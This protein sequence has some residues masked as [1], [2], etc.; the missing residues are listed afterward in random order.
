VVV[1]HT[2][3]NTM[4]L[5]LCNVCQY[6]AQ[7]KSIEEA[8]KKACKR[9][10]IYDAYFIAHNDIYNKIVLNPIPRRNKKL[11]GLEFTLLRNGK[12]TVKKFEVQHA[13]RKKDEKN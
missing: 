2:K 10:K 8:I 3:N 11:I 7:N 13:R 6:T 1:E 9:E 5:L 12:G 4:C